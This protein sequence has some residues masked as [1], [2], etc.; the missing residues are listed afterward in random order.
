MVEKV[1]VRD[2]EQM[3]MGEEREFR[4]PNL[5]QCRS[6]KS[7]AYQPGHD[8]GCKFR[9]RIDYDRCVLRLTKMPLQAAEI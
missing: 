1:T 8:L 7:L 5:G 2:L 4:L 3:A 6:G 9:V